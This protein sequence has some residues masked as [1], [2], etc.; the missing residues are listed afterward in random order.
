[1]RKTRG[2]RDWVKSRESRQG[3][4]PEHSKQ[5]FEKKISKCFLQLEVLLTRESWGKPRKSLS[6]LMIGPSTREQVARLSRKKY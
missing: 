3:Q 1:M 4:L 2:F 6:P 5:K